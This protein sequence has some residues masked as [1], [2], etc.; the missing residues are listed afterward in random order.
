MSAYLHEI[1][2]PYQ[3]L[4]VGKIEVQQKAAGMQYVARSTQ[5]VQTFKSEQEARDHILFTAGMDAAAKLTTV[6]LIKQARAME[7]AGVVN[8]AARESPELMR[9]LAIALAW[10]WDVGTTSEEAE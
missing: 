8:D 2:V 3:G 4:A 5:G 6:G 10:I 1:T 7:L 9:E